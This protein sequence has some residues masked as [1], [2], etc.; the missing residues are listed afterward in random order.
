LFFWRTRSFLSLFNAVWYFWSD[1]CMI[2]P[3]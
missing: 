1:F 2:S 3:D